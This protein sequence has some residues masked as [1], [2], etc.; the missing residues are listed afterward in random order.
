MGI[1]KEQSAK[2]AAILEQARG[3]QLVKVKME[4]E[5]RRLQSE[6]NQLKSKMSQ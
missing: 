6:T 1:D 5:I 2:R 4:E 3:Q